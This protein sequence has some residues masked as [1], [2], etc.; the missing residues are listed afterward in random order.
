[1]DHIIVLFLVSKHSI[2]FSTVAT[3]IYI[4][5]NSSVFSTS[6]TAFVI[7]RLFDNSHSDRCDV[8]L[9]FKKQKTQ[10]TF[11]FTSFLAA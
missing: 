7:C 1:M 3:P 6:L 5:T 10:E 9:F 2:P 4:L 11:L 8:R